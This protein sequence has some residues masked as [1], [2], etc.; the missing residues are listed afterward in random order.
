MEEQSPAGGAE[1]QVAEFVQDDEVGVGEYAAGDLSRLSLKLFLLEGVDEFNGREE[2]DALA[3]MLDGL[4][5][6]RRSEMRLACAGRG[7]DI[8]PGIRR[9]RGGSSY[10]FHP[11]NGL[12]VLIAGRC[13]HQST[14]VFVI[15]QPDDTLAHVPC[16]MMREA[17]AQHQLSPYSPPLPLACLRGLRL[18]VDGLLKLSPERFRS[19]K[20]RAIEV[21]ARSP[22]A[23]AV[24]RGRAADRS[25]V[26]A[27]ASAAAACAGDAGRDRDDIGG[28]GGAR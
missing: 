11:R 22:T 4:D 14:E 28:R 23:G 7:S 3:M 12:K 13:R 24:R 1:R 16:W 26:R 21:E 6:D 17:A 18:E 19:R 9:L 10:P 15:R 27:K 2:P 5:A 20:E 25:F 8:L